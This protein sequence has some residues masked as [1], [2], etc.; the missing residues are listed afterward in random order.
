[1]LNKKRG[2]Y[3]KELR[4]RKGLKQTD[5]AD[6]LHYSF[7]NISKW[8]NGKSF[9]ND[10]SILNKLAEILDVPVENLIY[11]EDN[12][13]ENISKN[14]DK[15]FRY[16]GF[17]LLLVFLLTLFFII[18]SK[19]HNYYVAEVSND[20]I[21]NSK[22]YIILEEDYNRFKFNKLRTSKEIELVSFYYERNGFNYLLIESENE[23]LIIT[24][25]SYHLEYDFES[26]VN[27]KCYLKVLYKDDSFD[28][29]KLKFKKLFS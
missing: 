20:Y 18:Y 15:K 9:P 26:I 5:V 14:S 8:E 29:F 23:E 7:K 17:S 11:G 13:L 19:Y 2:N 21:L 4:L 16:V 24:E 25:Y 12:A 3:L 27:D 1:M 10:P 22:I 28:I 6:L